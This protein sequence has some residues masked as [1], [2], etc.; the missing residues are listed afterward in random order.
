MPGMYQRTRLL[1]ML[2]QHLAQSSLEQMRSSVV[3][4]GGVADFRIDDGVDLVADA[5]RLLGHNFV[6]PHALHG[7]IAAH[8]LGNDRVVIAAVKDSAIA[9]LAA[10]LGIERSV[11]E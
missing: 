5:N 11:V 4:H 9:D 1:H 8:Y 7:G 2:T 10:G 3:A 6:C